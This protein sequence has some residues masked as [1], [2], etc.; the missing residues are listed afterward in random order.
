MSMLSMAHDSARPGLD[1]GFLPRSVVVC[2]G[3]LIALAAATDA[4]AAPTQTQAK[5]SS[6]APT[7]APVVSATAPGAKVAKPG[8]PAPKPR[9]PAK[10]GD[11]LGQ[12]LAE[13]DAAF[14]AKD[15]A[16]AL[17][18][19]RQVDAIE[20][21]PGTKLGIGA[22]LQALGKL[23]EA[24]DVYDQLLR[25]RGA[26]LVR[27]D[28]EKVEQSLAALR[29]S[30]AVL[31]L[32]VSESNA[33]VTVDNLPFGTTPIDRAVRRMPGRVSVSVQ[34]VGFEPW[35]QTLELRPG[36]ERRMAVDLVAD[37]N[38]A[39]LTVRSAGAEP[40]TLQ[41][42]GRDAGPL[43]FSGEVAAGD[44]QLLAKSP[45]GQ[46]AVRSVS[47]ATKGRY[48]VELAIMLTPAKIHVSAVD[49]EAT[50][51][52][53]AVPVA[54]GHFDGEVPPGNH[55]VTVQKSGFESQEL[56]L[57][58]EPGERTNLDNISL[59]PRDQAGKGG[60]PYDYSGF[61]GIVAL[62][63]MLGRPTHSIAT[64]CPITGTG[65]SC[66]S[67]LTSGVQ[68]DTRIGYS[69]GL[70]GL[71]GFLLLGTTFSSAQMTF[72]HDLSAQES[73]WYGIARNER[74]L[75]INPLVAAGAAGRISSRSQS[76]R[77]SSDWG[78][79][80]AW[81]KGQIGRTLEATPVTQQDMIVHN[82]LNVG[83]VGGGSRF[84]PI[85][86]WDVDVEVGNTPGLRFLFG[87]HCQLE[88][89]AGPSTN[90]GGSA[91]GY[92]AQTLSRL[93]TGGGDIQVWGSPSFFIGPRIGLAMAN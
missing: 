9:A 69:L 3:C 30:T 76:L 65:G 8:A 21:T 90:V 73:S 35:S 43:P 18:L 52:I 67:W 5:P 62:D 26:S 13:A 66:K 83:W 45:R 61:Y 17:E 23:V 33:Q 55:V 22:S 91:L 7:V 75:L 93:P 56:R 32:Q 41:I 87:L 82:D 64:D 10:P 11:R 36:E 49:P 4:V 72:D 31:A 20:P 48:E 86:I 81:H 28:F 37:R 63:G 44:H 70:V 27:H 57:S 85:V 42:D 80:I 34:K 89:G 53:D 58:V 51:Q 46:S 50:I 74:Y 19:Y 88:L 39:W 1:C 15:Y 77:L 60:E 12:H 14:T 84:L 2:C 16:R 25:E 71:E 47:A 38:Q 92:N 54:V 78:I 24:Y 79:G 29:A 40:A 6:G 59:V 68:L